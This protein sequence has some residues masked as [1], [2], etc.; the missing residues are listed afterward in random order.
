M[1]MGLPAFVALLLPVGWLVQ[2]SR[3][4]GEEAVLSDLPALGFGQAMGRAPAAVG[5][6]FDNFQ[7]QAETYAKE[8]FTHRFY[9]YFFLQSMF[10]F[11]SWQTGNFLNIRNRDSLGLTLQQMG[12]LAF[13]SA[14]VSLLMQ[15][16]A[17][18]LADKW[19]PIRVFTLTTFVTFGQNLFQCIFIFYKFE[20]AT[21]L[22]ILYW[23]SFTLMPFV[24][25]HGAAEIPMYMR[26]LPKERY[27]QFCSANAMVRSFALIFGSLLA[28]VF[29]DTMKA[30]ST[31]PDFHYRY[32]PVWAVVFQ[33]PAFI[34]LWLLYREWLKRGGDKGY[35]PPEAG[36][37]G[38][39]GVVDSSG[40][41][42][43]RH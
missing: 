26:L 6:W 24:V 5:R 29:M 30:R 3:R 34:F 40:G 16:P 25:L 9:W 1:I 43:A 33:I 22:M 35:T 20:P 8:C 23:L 19:N 17:G 21:N 13:I 2:G 27:G 31:E 28:G 36:V 32:Y 10:F 38:G 4:R 12:D 14:F 42:P 11:V 41:P 39:E 37:P 7:S 18:W 15:Y